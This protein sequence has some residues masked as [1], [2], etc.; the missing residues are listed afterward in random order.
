MNIDRILK[1]GVAV[2]L[3]LLLV[4]GWTNEIGAK[5]V[6]HL[7]LERSIDLANDSSLSAYR[8]RNQYL[9]G[10][11]AYRT[12]KA[13][14]LPSLTLN[15][16]PAKYYR[17][18][19][20]RYDSDSDKD[21]Y[22]EQQTFN[23]YGQLA[24]QQNFDWTGGTFY[25]NTDLEY[26]RSFGN[27]VGTQ[28]STV[29]IRIGYSQDLLGYN[30]FKWDKRIEPL[31]Y[32][33]VQ[34]QF[35]YNMEQMSESVVTYYFAL[36]LAQAELRL[37]E[38]NVMATD[39]LYEIGKRRHKIASISREDLLTLQLD[40]VNAQNTLLNA[41]MS[42]RRAAFSLA[43][44]L[45][46]DK[47]AELKLELPGVPM[48][49][50]ISADVALR[51]AHENNPQWLAHKQSVLEAEQTVDRTRKEA[52]FN[53]SINASVGF[54][55]TAERW[56]NAYHSPMQQDLVT[57]SVSIPLV[58]WGVRKGKYNVARN[59][60]NVVRT[61]AK[62]EELSLEEEVLMTVNDFNV[63]CH[64]ITSAQEALDLAVMAYE[65]TCRR[66]IIGKSDVNSLTLSLNRQQEA[67]K[68]YI[69]ALQNYWLSYYKIRRLTLFDF[70]SGRSLTNMLNQKIG[71]YK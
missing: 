47:D 52:R 50:E 58:D 28:Y 33:K 25:I 69:N 10:Y 32:E 38:E 68:N 19:T 24:I 17:Y 31:K 21:V 41:Q 34:K 59:E 3:L 63:Q 36:A 42:E 27:V 20:Q 51:K 4:G 48:H 37:A 49:M 40:K 8:Y 45:S 6:I 14:R 29:P 15:M 67:Q 61:E 43:T 35:L 56:R 54:N 7:T 13:N 2:G 71:T 22:R 39:T 18:I 26:L 46:I 64:M 11:W 70:A 53:A 57:L 65:Q 1:K 44:F 5:R 9:A 60:L 55:Q 12:Y 30:A 16:T 66:F 23:A 62:E